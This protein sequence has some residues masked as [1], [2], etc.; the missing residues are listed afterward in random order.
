[1]ASI[2]A[3][4]A[5]LPLITSGECTTDG[6][7]QWYVVHTK[8]NNERRVD[9]NLRNMDVETLCPMLCE[10]YVTSGGL[11][12]SRIKPLFPGYIFGRFTVLDHWH[13]V[14]FTRGVRDVLSSEGRPLPLHDDVVQ[15]VASRMDKDGLVRIGKTF[16]PGERVVIREG[17]FRDLAGIF[18]A[19][20][21]DHA[22]LTVLL[23]AVNWSARV[24]VSK[25]FLYSA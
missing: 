17:P 1:M 4:R 14:R 12:K 11:A 23:T 15:L 19:P 5:D 20:T 6:T 22:R 2:S 13:R 16:R 24:Q 9:H 3:E 25:E 10:G 18:E 8:P 21:N 7:P